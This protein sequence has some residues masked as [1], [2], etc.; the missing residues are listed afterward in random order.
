M[1]NAKFRLTVLITGLLLSAGASKTG[2]A[3]SPVHLQRQREAFSITLNA[4]FVTGSKVATG[5]VTL[6]SG[7][8][9]QPVTVNLSS[10]DLRIAQVQGT[11]QIEARRTSASFAIRT[12]PVSAPA[13]V[14]ITASISGQSQT[15]ALKVLPAVLEAVSVIGHG[16][17]ATGKVT[18]SVPAAAGG[19]TV[20][21]N[22]SNVAAAAVPPQIQVAGGSAEQTFSITLHPGH[23]AVSVR[24]K[25]EAL[26][27]EVLSNTLTVP[28][29][30]VSL[31]LAASVFGGRNVTALVSVPSA[32]GLDGGAVILSSSNQAVASVPPFVQVQPGATQ[33]RFDV[34]TF[35]VPNIVEVS[36]TASYG[37]LS[38]TVPITVK[39]PQLE[40][41]KFERA[42]VTGGETVTA[43]VTLADDRAVAPSGGLPLKCLVPT[44]DGKQS[45]M[46]LTV[47]GKAHQARFLLRTYPVLND[48]T[49]TMEADYSPGTELTYVV[50]AQLTVRVLH[51][52][53]YQLDRTRVTGGE[54][55]TGTI[56]LSGAQTVAPP[57]MELL[58]GVPGP[59]GTTATSVSVALPAGAHQVS[60]PVHTKPVAQATSFSALK[61]ELKTGGVTVSIVQAPTLTVLPAAIKELHFNCGPPSGGSAPCG[62]VSYKSGTVVTAW[63]TFTGNPVVGTLVLFS[64]T[65]TAAATVPASATIL[66][67]NETGLGVNVTLK[68]VSAATPFTLSAEIGGVVK[69]ATL[70]V[71]P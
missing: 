54:L 18:L 1:R 36:I 31:E 71:N 56:T 51:L 39:C 45:W 7:P 69:T 37:A 3:I 48:T 23:E 32:A 50:K 9:S 19:I 6:T 25:G 53:S 49:F 52:E 20:H 65:N 17:A 62:S 64:P 70:T 30:S 11:V 4:A 63:V 10:N 34:T 43:I 15:V 55:V 5:T 12:L 8:P 47:P 41:L 21:L 57:G 58:C 42:D 26:G 16:G 61:A 22:S 33:A 46:T 40:S 13:E 27:S 60:F 66:I 2:G 24:I 28:A 59:N 67:A 35:A 29:A 44:P 38:R 68:Q 14:K